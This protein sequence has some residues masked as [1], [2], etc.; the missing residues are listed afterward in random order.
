MLDGRRETINGIAVRFAH[1]RRDRY[2]GPL[3]L[4]QVREMRA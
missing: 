3:T 2:E 4:T 1:K